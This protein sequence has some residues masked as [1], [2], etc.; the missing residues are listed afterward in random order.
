MASTLGEADLTKDGPK[1]A[2][3]GPSTMPNRETVTSPEQSGDRKIAL[4]TRQAH[5]H[6]QN[7][8]NRIIISQNGNV[9]KFVNHAI[10]AL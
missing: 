5:V 2:Y 6:K 7:S 1:P 8:K 9:A 3:N 4:I 10:T